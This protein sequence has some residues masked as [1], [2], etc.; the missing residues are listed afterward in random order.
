MEQINK[1]FFGDELFAKVKVSRYSFSRVNDGI[2]EVGNHIELVI[3]LRQDPHRSSR[4]S[5]CKINNKAKI[6]GE[7][8]SYGPFDL[9]YRSK[10]NLI[11]L[12]KSRH[13]A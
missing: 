13:E 7:T 11:L 2:L 12:I 1:I 9:K 8:H 10:L 4:S 5:K 6:C 3:W